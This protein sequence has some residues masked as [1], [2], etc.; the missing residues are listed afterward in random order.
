MSQ[1]EFNNNF[2]GFITNLVSKTK[3]EYKQKKGRSFDSLDAQSVNYLTSKMRPLKL[4]DNINYDLKQFNNEIEK[5]TLNQEKILSE[6][7]QNTQFIINGSAG[8]GKTYIAIRAYK[9]ALKNKKCTIL[10]TY[11]KVLAL[12]LSQS[13]KI[14]NYD[15]LNNP[16][17]SIQELLDFKLNTNPILS[18][19]FD[20]DIIS[21]KI[22]KKLN[23]KKFDLLIIDEVQDVMSIPDIE[24]LIDNILINGLTDGNWYFFGDFQINQR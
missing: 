15:I 12:W 21:D 2:K 3:N 20:I 24:I 10:I 16:I 5:A 18:K 13:F 4:N 9:K 19:E 23:N 7:S 17:I 8:T 1:K 22:S 14:D 6:L 11:S